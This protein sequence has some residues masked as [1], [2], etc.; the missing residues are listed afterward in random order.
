MI[1]FSGPLCVLEAVTH[2]FPPLCGDGQKAKRKKGERE[3]TSLFDM[4]EGVLR[5][6][7]GEERSTQGKTKEVMG[8][9]CEE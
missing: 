4:V 9:V 2:A 8:K 5:V 1:H 6:T 3:D 7:E